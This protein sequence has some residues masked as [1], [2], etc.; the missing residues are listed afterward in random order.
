MVELTVKLVFKIFCFYIF[1]PVFEFRAE[2]VEV[3]PKLINT[4]I[5]QKT[6]ETDV[7]LK[8]NTLQ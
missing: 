3:F 1:K 2:I 4:R 6:R 8:L 5:C 7:I